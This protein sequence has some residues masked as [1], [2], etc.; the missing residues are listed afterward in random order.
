MTKESKI[1][2]IDFDGTCVGHDFP[3]VGKEI[4]AAPVLRELVENGHKLILFTMRCDH[5]FEP[6]AEGQPEI[7][8]KGGTY[9]TDA[10]N[11]FK[12]H[13]IPLWGIQTNPNQHTW[14]SSPKPYGHYIIDDTAIGCPLTIEEGYRPY[15]N[16]TKLRQLLIEQGLLN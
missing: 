10:V 14:T 8:A 4:G 3:N 12:G 15:V 13:N 9:L 7:I 11:W 2:L 5:D 16:W 1:F 6:A